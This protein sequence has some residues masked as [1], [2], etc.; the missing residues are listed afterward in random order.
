MKAAAKKKRLRISGKAR[1]NG[2][3]KAKHQ[4]NVTS[5]ARRRNK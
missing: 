3:R 4:E 5:N 2:S 1:G